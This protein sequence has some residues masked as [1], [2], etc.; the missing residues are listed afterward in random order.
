MKCFTYVVIDLLLAV[1]AFIVGFT[2][3]G[4]EY[5]FAQIAFFTFIGL[6]CYSFT[7]GWREIQENWS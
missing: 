2:E 5:W 1:V 3:I 6:A 7:M 4:G